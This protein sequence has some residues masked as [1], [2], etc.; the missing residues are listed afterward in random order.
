MLVSMTKNVYK[1]IFIRNLNPISRSEDR[2][3]LTRR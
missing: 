1:R 3:L 2:G